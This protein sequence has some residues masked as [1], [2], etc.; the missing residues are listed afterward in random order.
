MSQAGREP[1]GG[2]TVARCGVLTVVGFISTGV[3]LGSLA[4]AVDP[5]RGADVEVVVRSSDV[6]A[7][8]E[9]NLA[10]LDA[11]RKPEWGRDPFVLPRPEEVMAGTLHLTAILYGQDSSLAV[12]NGQLLKPGDNVEGRRILKIGEDYV[13]VREGTRTRRLEV[14]QLIAE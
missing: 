6:S 7:L 11:L 14:P 13:V 4:V 2:V 9:L 12:I 3:V 1:C 10:A 8:S 5:A